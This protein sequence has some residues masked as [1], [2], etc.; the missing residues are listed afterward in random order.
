[1]KNTMRNTQRANHRDGFT[2]IELLVVIAIIALLI[3]ILLPALGAARGTARSMVCASMQRQIALLQTS[4]A[5][6]NQDL[7]SGP[8]TSNLNHWWIEIGATEQPLDQLYFDS[9]PDAPTT[10]LDWISPILGDAVGLSPNRAART[11]Q[12]F[13]EYGCAAA[14]VFN[15]TIYRVN[16]IQDEEQFRET[17]QDRGF[18]QISYLAPTAFYYLS[19]DSPIPVIQVGNGRLTRRM[20]ET[21]ENAAVSP[22]G[23]V[24]RLDRVGISTSTKIMFSDGTRFASA[25]DGL[26]FDPRLAPSFF[27]SFFANNPIIQGSSAFGR[28]PFNSSIQLPENQLLSFRHPNGSINA[29]YFDGHAAG[30]PQAEAYSNPNPWFPSGSRWTGNSATPESIQFMAE[31][32]GGNPA[33]ARIY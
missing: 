24:P 25:D 20:K 21:F 26:D 23:F 2:L 9:D 11:S 10:T 7:Y 28:M 18:L 33:R 8:N 22:A 16:A 31:Q 12:L 27:G 19:Y 13:N 29:A 3:G 6:D 1:M 32:S 5:L 15:D 4:Y 30:M 17:L 14:R